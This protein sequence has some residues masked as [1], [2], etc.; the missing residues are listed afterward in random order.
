MEKICRSTTTIMIVIIM[1]YRILDGVKKAA[2]VADEMF[3]H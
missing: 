2:S 1:S 3:K